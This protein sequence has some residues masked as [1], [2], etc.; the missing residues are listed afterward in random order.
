MN[1]PLS[2]VTL[3]VGICW[4]PAAQRGCNEHAQVDCIH[5]C[6]VDNPQ[7]WRG[8]IRVHSEERAMKRN[9]LTSIVGVLIVWAGAARALAASEP[10][11]AESLVRLR[12]EIAKR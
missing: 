12:A 4:F 11:D 5:R 1:K 10:I 2:A 6:A 3:R 7:L 9:I 8:E